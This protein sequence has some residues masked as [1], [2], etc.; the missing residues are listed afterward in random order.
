[1]STGI[2]DGRIGNTVMTDPIILGHEA[3][4]MITALGEGV[5]GLK[6][7][8]RVA[9]E[10]AK[11]CMECE[12]CKGGS[13]QRLPRHSFFRHPADGRLPEGLH[14]LARRAGHQDSR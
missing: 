5:E 13:F 3:S 14:H 10:P 8:D 7:G 12:F 2:E 11:P 6:V 1:M 9:I 4:G